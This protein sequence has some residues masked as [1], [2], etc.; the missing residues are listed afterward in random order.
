MVNQCFKECCDIYHKREDSLH[1]LVLGVLTTHTY[2]ETKSKI[3]NYKTLQS[4][5]GE[6]RGSCREMS[7]T[8]KRG[9]DEVSYGWRKQLSCPWGPSYDGNVLL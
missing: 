7:G 8:E 6:G 9:K 2:I 4:K 3:R 1:P 5:P